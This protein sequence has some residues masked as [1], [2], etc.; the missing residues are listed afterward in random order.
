MVQATAENAHKAKTLA[1]E[2]RA[3]EES[4][5]RTMGELIVAMKEINASTAQVAKIVKDIDEIAFQTNI[6]ALNAAVE[7][8]RAGEA[9][10]G[11]AVVADEVRS[12]AQRSAAAAKET[13]RKIELAIDS[14][15]KG[16]QCTAR[17]GES[18]GQITRKVADTDT[19]V[20]E[21]ATAAHEQARGIEQI[22]QALGQIDK[23]SQANASDAEGTAS[24]AEQ[25][26]AQGEALSRL[27]GQLQKLVGGRSEGEASTAVPASVS[28]EVFSEMS[29]VK[30]NRSQSPAKT[31]I[32][33]AQR[34]ELSSATP[35]NER[36]FHSF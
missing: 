10:A 22:T 28:F 19:L 9:G 20:S 23:V 31:Q 13:S 29:A 7:A 24:A 6:L 11:F 33:S 15:R 34:R 16:D 32:K 14:S 26:E 25:V 4:G 21:I 12:L 8:A 30:P 36:D 3:A 18:L 27:V 17:V 35:E 1:S 5:T 2:T